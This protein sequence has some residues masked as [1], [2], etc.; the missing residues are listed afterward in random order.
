MSSEPYA[1]HKIINIITIFDTDAICSDSAIKPS[2]DIEKP[3]L[4][5]NKFAYMVTTSALAISG[6]GTG[7]IN[8]KAN[9]DDIIRWSA[10]SESSNSD[11][12]VLIH[13]ISK[14]SGIDVFRV[15]DYHNRKRSAMQGGATTAIP[16]AF[17]EQQHWFMQSTL[18]AKGRE[19][20][21]IQ[22]ALYHRPTG[23]EQALYSYF[24]IASILNVAS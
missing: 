3:V 17:V 24:Q 10:T 20:Y 13:K 23:N 5:D 11:S 15:P 8:V 7:N 16:P 14:K 6:S 18:Q 1:S 9:I 2:T 4:I 22:F 21:Y 19:E 12:S